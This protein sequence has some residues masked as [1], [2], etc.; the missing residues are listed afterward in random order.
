MSD[1]TVADL[2]KWDDK[3]CRVGEDLGLDW[4]PIDYEI[5]DYAEMLGAMAYTGLPTH[6]RHWSYGKEY[7]RTHTLYNMGQTGLPYE[8]IINSNPSIAYL[9]RENALY[10][11]ILTMAHCVG[12]SDFFKQNRMFAHT[13]PSNIISS[14]KSAAKYVRQLIED[15]SIGIDKVE[16]ILDAAHSIKYQVPRY[17]GIKYKT[18]AEIIE[19]EKDKMMED[20]DYN[21]NLSKVPIRPEYNL[22]RFI[23]EHSKNLEEWERNLILIVEESSKYFIPQALTKVMNEGWACTIHQKIINELNLPDNLYLPFVKL[24]NQVIRPHL[25]QINPYHLGYTLFQKI[26]EEKGFEEAKTIRE[27]HN[28]I[29]FLRFYTDE[30][31]MREHNYFSYSFNKKQQSSIVDDISDVEGW[32]KVRD[33]MITNVGLNRIPVVFVEEIEKD[34]T[35]SLVHEHD[36]R[37]LEMNYA[38]KV[39]E[40]I[41]T[42]W[43]GE[44]KLITI[45]EDEIWEF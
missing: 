12:H 2:Q 26:I 38:R 22:L 29:T 1:W 3:I 19:S 20:P 10:I 28:D 13:D 5:I 37:D 23:A 32:E 30:E 4:F 25:G 44:V 14:F 41:K 15:P 42:L 43:R 24:H 18:R 34:G 6:Y 39:F 35:L 31:F 21:P 40:H 27:V 8:M 9:M 7:E 16:N 36:G 33:A 45:V 11:H 17:P